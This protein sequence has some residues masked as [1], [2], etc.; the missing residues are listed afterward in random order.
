[1]NCILSSVY[2]GPVSYYMQLN[3]HETVWTEVYDNYQKQSYR[4]RCTIASPNGVQTLSIPVVKPQEGKALMK[5]IRISD[6][7]NWRHL[8]WNALQ[9]AYGSSPFF[10]F[11]ADDFAR[12]YREK[13]DS[14]ADYNE[15]LQRLVC[16]LIG[17]A[18]DVSITTSF[19]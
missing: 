19:V 10:E 7:G 18:S 6:H 11:Y 15:Q 14:L 13:W 17:I 8:H 12:F 5:D 2:L 1:M 9:S 16:H 3:R 4:N